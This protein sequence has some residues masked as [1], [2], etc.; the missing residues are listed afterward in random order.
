MPVRAA[1]FQLAYWLLSAFYV[2]VSLP[3][4]A[5]PGHGP[6]RAIIRSYTRA[7]NLALRYIAGVGKQVR[8]RERLPEGAFVVGA[9]HQSW[10]DGFLVYPEIR[11]LA[12]V[13]G[14]P[15]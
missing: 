1:L 6:V 14:D 8:G 7:M 10:G 5:W 13:T 12:F 4:L 11:D 9:K 2:A 15:P 3:F